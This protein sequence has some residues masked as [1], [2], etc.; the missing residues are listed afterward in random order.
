MTTELQTD[1]GDYVSPQACAPDWRTD[2]DDHLA[3]RVWAHDPAYVEDEYPWKC[4]ACFRYL[5][6]CL[7]Y[8]AYCQ[9]RGSDVVF[10]SPADCR[11]V[12][13]TDHR[14]VCKGE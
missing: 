2:H 5:Q 14:V 9:D 8:V 1:L 3:F 6:E 12:R 11:L 4:V 13:T 10:Q 7:D